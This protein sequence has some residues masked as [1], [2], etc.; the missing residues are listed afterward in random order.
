MIFLLLAI[1]SVATL[2]QAGYSAPPA[3]AVATVNCPGT[4]MHGGPGRKPPRTVT[5]PLRA[6]TARRVRAF[7]FDGVYVL[8]PSG[9]RCTGSSGSSGAFVTAHDPRAGSRVTPHGKSWNSAVQIGRNWAG[10]LHTLYASCGVFRAAFEQLTRL[11][12]GNE[13][14][15]TTAEV[16]PG[17]R[18]TQSMNSQTRRTG[19]RVAGHWNLAGGPNRTLGVQWFYPRPNLNNLSQYVVCALPAAHGKLCEQLVRAAEKTLLASR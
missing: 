5:V 9:F 11:A 16:H 13:S 4:T 8:A 12:P 17:E 10:T 19:P 3:A 14:F 1:A 7:W 18:V 2:A 15:C 6:S